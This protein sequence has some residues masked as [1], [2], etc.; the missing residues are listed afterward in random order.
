MEKKIEVD[1]YHVIEEFLLTKGVGVV[2][3]ELMIQ[4]KPL[5]DFA[6]IVYTKKMNATNRAAMKFDLERFFMRRCASE[7]V[8]VE[9]K[10]VKV[11]MKIFERVKEVN[12][13]YRKTIIEE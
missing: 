8:G 5:V 3:S 10:Y 13:Q 11:P 1:G 6:L 7:I 2:N 12:D 9:T 4:F